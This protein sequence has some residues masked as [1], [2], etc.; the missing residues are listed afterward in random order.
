MGL[1]LIGHV[2]RIGEI[3]NAYRVLVGKIYVW[4]SGKMVRWESR[5][6]ERG[7]DERWI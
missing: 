7:E 1:W 5:S 2:A 4:E 3:S 6:Y